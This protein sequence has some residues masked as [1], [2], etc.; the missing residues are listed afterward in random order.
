[1]SALRRPLTAAGALAALAA[2][3]AVAGV[4]AAPPA[5]WQAWQHLPGVFDLAGPRPDGTVVAAAAGRLYQIAPD[6]RISPF[7]DG[8]QGYRGT[9]GAEAY[10]ALS[11]GLA[12]SGC[13]FASGDLFVLDLGA[14][15]GVI[16]VSPDGHA[17]AFASVPAAR[18]LSGIAFDTGGRFGH[19]LL[20][21][22]PASQ[23]DGMVVA[24][25]DCR[26]GVTTVGHGLP[27]FEGGFAVAPPGFGAHA[28]ELVVPDEL[29]GRILAVT[30]S[31][32]AEE[33]AAS[34]VEHG[35]DIG[36]ESAGVVPLSGGV[37]VS[38]R[39][40]PGNPHPGT[41]TVLRIEQAAL[42]AAGVA[43]GDILIASEGGAV[44]VDLR[45]A[46][47]CTVRTVASG[48]PTAH[49]E[50][51]V[52]A[53]GP[54]PQVAAAPAATGGQGGGRGPLLRGALSLL[55]GLVVLGATLRLRARVRRQ[56][57]A[58]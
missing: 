38:D 32:Q 33:L 20:V 37:L 22:G 25:I 54:V 2:S 50:G 36:V 46:A 12:G 42:A 26:G 19:R 43:P 29:S 23:G 56:R 17:G 28:G 14:V 35:G 57:A 18:T 58:G 9:D 3:W 49:G 47:S 1:M 16:R 7:A 39:G 51:H 10:I 41:D 24:A 30:P 5:T 53:L 27:V 48:P 44:T 6:G 8:P 15:P 40:T 52:L 13:R 55:V 21:A 31:G 11:P 45:C 4:V 34:G